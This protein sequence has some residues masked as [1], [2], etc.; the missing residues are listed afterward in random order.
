MLRAIFA[1]LNRHTPSQP[2]LFS[3]NLQSASICQ[4]SGQLST[5]RCPPMI[6]SFLPNTVPT[7]TCLLHQPASA[8]LAQPSQPSS[9][10][11]L[12]QPTPGLQLAID[13]RLPDAREAFPFRLPQKIT[14]VR[15]QWLVDGQQVGITHVAQRQFLWPLSRGRHTVQARIWIVE[16]HHPIITPAVEFVVK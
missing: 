2:L 3:P 11:Q 6:E 16:R 8:A 1:E 14:P 4:L 9:L 10:I 12:L 7:Q 15:T 13:P 5:P